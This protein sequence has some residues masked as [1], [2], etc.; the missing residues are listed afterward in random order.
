MAM[1]GG[2]AAAEGKAAYPLDVCVVSGEKLGEHGDAYVF[3]HDGQ[4]VRLCCKPCLKDFKKDPGKYLK[5]IQDA[6]KS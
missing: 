2:G 3:E 4:E 1:A 6:R 5:K